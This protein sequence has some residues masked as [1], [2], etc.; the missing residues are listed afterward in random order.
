MPNA[1]EYKSVVGIDEVH[2]ALVTQDDADNYAAGTPAVF[3]P[4]I[5][6]SAEPSTSLETQY[7]DNKPFDVMASEGETKITLDV[8][9]IPLNILAIYLGK[10]FDAASGRIFDAGGEAVPPDAAFSF[11]SM[12]SN[13]SYRYFQYLKGKFSLPK[14]EAAT[15]AESME[16]KPSQ[17]VYT[18]V[19]TLYKFDLGDSGDPKSVKRIVGDEDVTNFSATG[20]FSQVQTPVTTAPDAL[21]LDSSVPVDDATD[22]AIASDQTLTFNN[23]LT[24]ASVNGIN[25]IDLSTGTIVPAAVSLNVTKKIITVNPTDNLS[26]SQEYHLVYAVTDIYGQTLNGVISFTTIAA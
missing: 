16:P 13:G 26:N 5:N 11:R 2:V 21:A 1:A 7:A 4:A 24:D 12:K 10:Q 8:T 23:A 6:I 19:N 20:W 17:I 3:A 15:K 14:D 9:N 25:L 18:A 22:I